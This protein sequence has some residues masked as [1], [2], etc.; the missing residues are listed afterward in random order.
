MNKVSL[1]GSVLVT[2]TSNNDLDLSTVDKINGI[3]SR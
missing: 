3:S 2:T 1:E